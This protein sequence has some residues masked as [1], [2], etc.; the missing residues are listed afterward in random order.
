MENSVFYAILFI[1]GGY[2]TMYDVWQ[3][4][5]AEIEQQISVANFSTWFQNTSL[6]SIENGNIRIGVNNSVLAIL[7]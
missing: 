6:L 1:K 7:I 4:V 5:L 2:T 3:N